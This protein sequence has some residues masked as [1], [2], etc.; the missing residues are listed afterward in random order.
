MRLLQ[1]LSILIIGL[2]CFLGLFLPTEAQAGGQ[3]FVGSQQAGAT[4]FIK[5]VSASYQ[6]GTLA[7]VA[8]GV[9]PKLGSFTRPISAYYPASYLAAKGFLTGTDVTVPVFG[10]YAGTTN[11]VA[12]VFT[13]TDGSVVNPY[14]TVSTDSCTDPCSLLNAPVIQ[15]HRQSTAELNFD[16]FLLKDSFSPNSP[17]ILDTDG[18]VRWVGFLGVGAQP[19]TVYRNGI[20]TSDG[21]TGVVRMELYGTAAKIG[22]Y[23]AG[24]GVTYTG[25]HNM[26]I[27]RNGIVLEVDTATQYEATALEFDDATGNVLQEWDMGKII[28]AAM[29]AGGDD[30]SQFVYLSNSA[31]PAAEDWFHMN[32]TAYNPAD[33]TLIVS[34]RENFVVAVDYDVPADGV[35]KIHWI[36]GDPTKKWYVQFPSLRKFALQLPAGT[37]PPIGQHGISIDLS[38]NLLLFDDGYGSAFQSPPG[39]TRGYSAARSYKVDTKAMTATT[40]FEYTP[41][42]PNIYSYICGSVYQTG[43]ENYLVDFAAAVVNNTPTMVIQG[44][45]NLNQ[46]VFD[47]RL[48]E[49]NFCGVG[50]NALPLVG[51]FVRY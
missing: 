14:V 43:P 51:S 26:D 32:A 9:V 50:W 46:V 35:R 45:G 49:Y 8:F 36:L 2:V 1:R 11:T 16:Y 44:L 19:S 10:L 4:P 41:R 37:L 6:G 33:N 47:L 24:Y 13:F 42:N 3:V 38:G 21:H 29:A 39:V 34:S 31:N 22:D 12:L 25:N 28:G 23:A 15:Q 40:V 48:P 17:A 5:L 30:P 7:G 27:G 18:N 20:Y